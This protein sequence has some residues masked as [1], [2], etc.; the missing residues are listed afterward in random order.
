MQLKNWNDVRYLLALKR[1]K[2]LSAAARLLG[3]DDTTVSRRL[4]VLQQSSTEPLFYRHTDGSMHLSDLGDSLLVH[5]ENIEQ[6]F[7][8]INNMLGMEQQS[9]AGVVRITSVPMVVNHILAPN[10]ASLID[11][12]PDLQVELI[13]DSRDLNLTQREA[14][15]AIRLARPVTGGLQIKIRKLGEL[16]C[17]VYALKKFSHARACRLPWIGYEDNLS[18]IAPQQW[19]QKVAAR[20]GHTIANLKVQDVET[21]LQ[22]VLAGLGRAVLPDAIANSDSRLRIVSVNKTVGPPARELWL[23]SHDSQVGLRRIAEV[24]NW[25]DG[26]F[27]RVH[28]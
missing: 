6:Q 8:Q 22:S 16:S 13:P 12:N 15:L 3:V 10:I 20:Q 17:S 11:A 4:G 28:K 5:V 25:I 26:V 23:L 2:S 9:C 24:T 18:H 21:A 14:D 1:G 27:G 7:E 19:M